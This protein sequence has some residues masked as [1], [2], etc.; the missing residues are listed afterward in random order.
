[1]KLDLISQGIVDMIR[2]GDRAMAIGDYKTVVDFNLVRL[3]QKFPKLNNLSNLALRYT[4]AEAYEKLGETEN[5]LTYYRYCA[6]HGG[7]TAIR[8]SAKAALERLM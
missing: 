2:K 4:L 1:M 3:E 5:A 8:S 7:E 6:E